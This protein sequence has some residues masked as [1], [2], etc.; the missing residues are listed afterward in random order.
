MKE[1][2]LREKKAEG[3]PALEAMAIRLPPCEPRLSLVEQKK[4]WWCH[5]EAGEWKCGL[6]LKGKLGERLEQCSQ[7]GLGVL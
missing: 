6:H 1:L 5:A 3:V 4:G 2:K 7:S